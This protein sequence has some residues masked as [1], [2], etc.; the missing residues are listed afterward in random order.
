MNC[1]LADI[2]RGR[3]IRAV[4]SALGVERSHVMQRHNHVDDAELLEAVKEIARNSARYGYRRVWAVLPLNSQQTNYKRI[5]RVM[6]DH[7]LLLH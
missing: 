5:Y 4:C 7:R 6:Q 2:F 3:E 1:G